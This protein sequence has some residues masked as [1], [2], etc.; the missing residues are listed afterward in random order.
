VTAPPEPLEQRLA[1]L[2]RRV[3]ELEDERAIATAFT[4]YN[5][6]VNY[7]GDLASVFVEDAVVE[8][9]APDGTQLV[10]QEGRDAYAAYRATLPLPP[11]KWSKNLALAPV[12][13]IDG[14]EARVENY[15][16]VLSE[17][18]S[19]PR[20]ATFGRAQTTLV[21]GQDGWLIKS[22]RAEVEAPARPGGPT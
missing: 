21:R 1:E 20:V 17:E 12:V 8:V 4:R 7:G 18:G 6:L 10:R 22:R 2:E 9:V 15:F 3:R 19:G 11:Q 14:D 5:R 16:V 13:A